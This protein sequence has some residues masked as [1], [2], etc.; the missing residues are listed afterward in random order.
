MN[1]P[2]NLFSGL[3][4]MNGKTI[5]VGDKIRKYDYVMLGKKTCKEYLEGLVVFSHG[6]YRICIEIDYQGNEFPPETRRLG[7]SQNYTLLF[8]QI[9]G[10]RN[11][12][13]INR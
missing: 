13:V 10:T 12:E 7:L 11:L 1:A 6:A 9:L 4:D 2:F 3:S 5:M 8:D